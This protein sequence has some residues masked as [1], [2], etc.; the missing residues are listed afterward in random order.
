[1]NLPKFSSSTAFIQAL[2]WTQQVSLKTVSSL[3]QK[4]QKVMP[5]VIQSVFCFAFDA[6]KVTLQEKREC[7]GAKQSSRL[8]SSYLSHS[9]G[10]LL[11]LPAGP[12]FPATL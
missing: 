2:P 12:W 11:L 4:Y 7:P 8:E 5:R 1:M 6:Q 9:L 3:K 10:T